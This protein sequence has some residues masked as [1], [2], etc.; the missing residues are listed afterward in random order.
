M[1]HQRYIRKKL[2]IHEHQAEQIFR[3]PSLPSH[4]REEVTLTL[5]SSSY[6]Y[7]FSSCGL[8]TYT[9][10][11]T[12]SRDVVLQVCGRKDPSE[13]RFGR[14]KCNCGGSK[15]SLL[16]C[17]RVL[18]DGWRASRWSGAEDGGE[19]DTS[20]ASVRSMGRRPQYSRAPSR[21]LHNIPDED[22][23]V[24][25]GR[26][27]Y[28]G[29][30]MSLPRPYSASSSGNLHQGRGMHDSADRIAAM[31]G[32][33]RSPMRRPHSTVGGS[34]GEYL[35]RDGGHCEQRQYNN[36]AT[37]NG[38]QASQYSSGNS[39]QHNS[40]DT[41]TLKQ[42]VQEQL[43]QLVRELEEGDDSSPQSEWQGRDRKPLY[44]SN[45]ALHLT[46]PASLAGNHRSVSN[47]DLSTVANGPC[48]SASSLAPKDSNSCRA[49]PQ[50]GRG[51][52]ASLVNRDR[53]GSLRRVSSP[54][55]ELTRLGSRDGL[56]LDSLRRNQGRGSLDLHSYQ[57]G[58]SEDLRHALDSLSR[59]DSHK[60]RRVS[61]MA[62]SPSHTLQDKSDNRAPTEN[63]VPY[64]YNDVNSKP[65]SKILPQQPPATATANNNSDKNNNSNSLGTSKSSSGIPIKAN[66]NSVPKG[67]GHTRQVENTTTSNNNNNNKIPSNKDSS[68]SNSNIP[69]S[70]SD[71]LQPMK[72]YH[73]SKSRELT[74]TIEAA[75]EK[76]TQLNS[77]TLKRISPFE[78]YRRSKSRD[79]PIDHINANN[80]ESSSASR[81]KSPPPI[82]P[83]RPT[84]PLEKASTTEKKTDITKPPTGECEAG[85]QARAFSPQPSA[86][87]SRSPS[88]AKGDTPSASGK[89]SSRMDKTSDR[90]QE[91]EQEP[92]KSE[93]KSKVKKTPSGDSDKPKS[94]YKMLTSRFNRSASF[95][96]DSNRSSAATA[97]DE[98]GGEKEDKLR[99]KRPSRFL[100]LRTEK[101]ASKTSMCDTEDDI[102]KPEKKPSKKLTDALNK[103]LGRKDTAK[104]EVRP[105][106]HVGNKATGQDKI[107]QTNDQSRKLSKAKGKKND[108]D[109]TNLHEKSCN[110]EESAKEIV[111]Q[112]NPVLASGTTT[113]TTTTTTATTTTATQPGYTLESATKSI[114]N[115]L[116]QLES[117]MTSRIG[118]MGTQEQ[119]GS[120]GGG[121]RPS[122]S[123]T[124][125]IAAAA[126]AAATGTNIST[127]GLSPALANRRNGRPT[128]LDTAASNMEANQHAGRAPSAP[129]PGR[130]AA[131]TRTTVASRSFTTEVDKV[132]V[133]KP[134]EPR[135]PSP[136]FTECPE[137]QRGGQSEG[138]DESVMD[139]IT[140]K[141]YYSK[142]Q[143][144]KRPKLW[145]ANTK[146][147]MDQQLAAAK[148]RLLKEE[149]EETA[150]LAARRLSSPR[151]PPPW[152]PNRPGTR[153]SLP[154]EEAASLLQ[155]GGRR[156]S[157]LQPDHLP[158]PLPP[159][160]SG[161][162]AHHPHLPSLPP[163]DPYLYPRAPSM[164]RDDYLPCGARMQPGQYG[165]RATSLAPDDLSGQPVG[166]PYAQDGMTAPMGPVPYMGQAGTNGSL[167]R[168]EPGHCEPP[169]GRIRSPEPA[170]V[171]ESRSQAREELSRRLTH[172]TR[173]SGGSGTGS[174]IH[175]PHK[176]GEQRP[177]RRT[178]TTGHLT[179]EVTGPPV[180]RRTNTMDLPPADA[181]ARPGSDYRRHLQQEPARRYSAAR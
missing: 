91:K 88:A 179:G 74:P 61:S 111:S 99:L 97:D 135:S 102:D 76:I 31:Y 169:L 151:S 120:S 138:E 180:Y 23:A 11:H 158:G 27:G 39:H 67:S 89:A 15:P 175:N 34:P 56:G 37:Q 49:L 181:R 46:C 100:N 9:P 170:S 18:D 176:E 78:A 77:G 64:S 130:A 123:S 62:E 7:P 153:T 41:E 69:C 52:S 43:Q 85:G 25:N 28:L 80:K 146:E 36:A 105:T 54:R 63:C 84:S 166:E 2:K 141:S 122:G 162:P 65:S 108:E 147:D 96:S 6:S 129:P 83:E 92:E 60:P 72:V 81:L 42:S 82:S 73:K 87:V 113:T 150:A 152:D 110:G 21:E 124:G 1:A 172:L 20:E 168:G 38:A 119:R 4:G 134:Q 75:S 178:S 29:G 132:K 142:F 35:G 32:T 3:P 159:L 98:E 126:A 114:C 47:A 22:M 48:M 149:R 171:E 131:S 136:P 127:Y 45:P 163:N 26:G 71:L 53:T 116:S 16:C 139:R 157:S 10:E 117:D 109:L 95:I 154:P 33:L 112:A 59:M 17:Y 58:R 118:N 94:M 93:D 155:V 165:R 5:S 174:W 177:Y 13:L 30:G 156:S 50:T 143:D 12:N 115:H 161:E 101:S 70:G 104:E 137:E 14:S 68:S 167:Q 19:S 90:V 164:P 103:F 160:I 128:N 133:Q 107:P 86:S 144:K 24:P 44:S 106:G 57:R 40:E 173:L 55:G 121:V 51:G 125:R 8:H 145:R 79:L 148:A 140:R 66:T